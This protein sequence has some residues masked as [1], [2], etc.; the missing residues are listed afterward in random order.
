MSQ[1]S[2]FLKKSPKAWSSTAHIGAVLLLAVSVGVVLSRESGQAA[3]AGVS[4]QSGAAA[5]AV[6]ERGPA[7]TS[8]T[9]IRA[10]IDRLADIDYASRSKAARVVRR[11]AAAQAVPAL[12]QAIGQHK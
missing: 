9:E 3:T 8:A 1:N 2:H 7:A 12:L 10:A 6:Q 5:K 11:A 4:G